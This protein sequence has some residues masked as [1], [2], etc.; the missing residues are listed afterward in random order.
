MPPNTPKLAQDATSALEAASVFLF[1]PTKENRGTFLDNLRACGIKNHTIADKP[2]EA[3]NLLITRHFDVI[4]LCYMGNIDTLEQFI[5]ELKSLDTIAGIPLLAITPDGSSKNILRIMSREV[6]RV[7]ITPLSRKSMQE[8]LKG[9]LWVDPTDNTPVSLQDARRYQSG[10]EWELAE[11]EYREILKRNPNQIEALMGLSA[12]LLQRKQNTQAVEY[13]KEA[14]KSAKQLSDVVEQNRLLS[15]IYATLGGHFATLGAREQAIKHYKAALKLNPFAGD[16][17]LE[18]IPLMTATEKLEDILGY[19]GG[20]TENYPPYSS[21]RDKVSIVLDDLLS[22]YTLLNMAEN[23]EQI[24][25]YLLNMEHSNVN[26]HIK[27]VDFL[28]QTGRH[29]AIKTLLEALL[30]RIKDADIMLRLADLYVSDL[31]PAPTTGTPAQPPGIDR[32]YLKNHDSEYWL[33]QSEALY[34]NALL[35]DP[36]EIAIWLRLLRCHLLLKEQ[37]AANQLLDRMFSNMT[38][39][40]SEHAETCALLLQEKAYVQA[41]QYVESGLKKYPLES[42]FHLLSSQM[43]NAEGNHYEAITALKTGLREQPDSSECLIELGKTYSLVK[44][45]SQAVEVFEKA[46]MLNPE[47]TELPHL[48]QTALQSKYRAQGK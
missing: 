41:R 47:N 1:Y 29:T 8:A 48:L 31:H 5:G 26:L 39:G 38:I 13:L 32:D 2:Q 23:I 33:R 3:I 6:D 12:L 18:L 21:F 37:S 35:L 24:H 27:T 36:F 4:M 46:Q 11:L 20:L 9:F 43:H 44:N 40:M 42:R 30:T 34:K 14:M 10:G 19:L 15:M 22:R 17:L 28:Q 16:I 25:T 45:W 7:L